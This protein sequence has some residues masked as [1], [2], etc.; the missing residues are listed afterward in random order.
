MAL[1]RPSTVALA[2][3]IDSSA[4]WHAFVQHDVTPSAALVRFLVAV[5]V[6]AAML[7]LLRAVTEPYRRSGPTIRAVAERMDT[8]D[9][10]G[11]VGTADAETRS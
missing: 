10:T 2:A 9:R 7:G 5:P 4:L 6:S 11:P 1:A 3:V 8:V